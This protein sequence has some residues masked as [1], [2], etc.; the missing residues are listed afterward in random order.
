[1]DKIEIHKVKRKKMELLI[2]AI[3]YEKSGNKQEA[4]R[5]YHK[6]IALNQQVLEAKVGLMRLR[7]EWKRFAGVDVEY[8]NFFQDAQGQQQIQKLERW[9]IK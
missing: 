4:I 1:M 7:G 6:L 8:R 2:K 9:L 3:A 5:I